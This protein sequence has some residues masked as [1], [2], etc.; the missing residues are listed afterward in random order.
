MPPDPVPSPW[1]A[2][3][4]DVDRQIGSPVALHCLGGFVVAARHGLPRP[5][6]DIDVLAATPHPHLVELLT[7]AGKG[8]ALARRHHL[9]VDPVTVATVPESYEARLQPLF[10]NRFTHLRLFALDPYD[11]V[12]AKLERNSEVDRDDVRLLARAVP[13][14]VNVLRRRYLQELRPL[15]GNA[16][17]EDLTIDLWAEMIAEA[18]GVR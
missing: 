2:F 3:L 14:E 6:A 16:A 18:R 9:Y 1:N 4:D 5:T 13:L 8:S 15:L 7:I 17:R 12:L 11:L 10:P